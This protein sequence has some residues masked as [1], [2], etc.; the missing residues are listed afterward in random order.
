[1]CV[2]HNRLNRY[3]RRPTYPVRTPRDAVSEID[4]ETVYFSCFD[5][6]NGY[7]KNTLDEASQHLTVFMTPWGRYKYLRASM[8]L[9][10]SSDEFNRRVDAAFSHLSNIVRTVDD[11]LRFDRS[12]SAPYSKRHGTPASRFIR[13]ILL[14]TGAREMGRLHSRARRHRRGSRKTKSDIRFCAATGHHWAPLIFW[15]GGT[16]RRFLQFHKWG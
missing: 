6:T 3:V 16:V 1:M 9:S 10:C 7:F 4:S 11:L 5:A 8:G 15:P 14:C 12:F 13:K 2:D